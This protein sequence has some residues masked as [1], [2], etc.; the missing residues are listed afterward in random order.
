MIYQK[1]DI[2]TI[3]PLILSFFPIRSD[4][5][6]ALFIY[7]TLISMCNQSHGIV[8]DHKYLIY[9]ALVKTLALNNNDL[10]KYCF[11]TSDFNSLVILLQALTDEETSFQIPKIL[12]NDP[13]KLSYF[14]SRF[15]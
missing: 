2:S 3:F 6:E 11:E 15:N 10:Q 13:I 1:E 5:E 14:Y 4:Y 9:S 12:N 8:F 7:R